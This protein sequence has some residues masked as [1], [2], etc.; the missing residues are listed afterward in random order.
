MVIDGSTLAKIAP[1]LKPDDNLTQFIT[2]IVDGAVLTEEIIRLANDFPTTAR[3]K[4]K[5]DRDL[6]A[7]DAA[8]TS[9][10]EQMLTAG[11]AALPP[12]EKAEIAAKVKSAQQKVQSELEA[13]AGPEARVEYKKRQGNEMFK[14]KDY[15]QAA[16]LYTEAIQIKDDIPALWSNRCMCF[17]KLGQAERALPDAERCIEIDPKFTKAHFRRGVA[18]LELGRII[19]ALQSFRTVLDLDPANKQA[20]ASM[21][22]AEKKLADSRR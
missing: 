17:L 11:G 7:K 21:M 14:A 15:T 22:L 6:K 10:A 12:K 2:R 19:E 8:L 3:E 5:H 20:K 18:L 16:V 1:G 9:M 13:D 4:A